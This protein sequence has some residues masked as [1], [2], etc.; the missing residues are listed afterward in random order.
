[1]GNKKIIQILKK[2]LLYLIKSC[3]FAAEYIQTRSRILMYCDKFMTEFM[4]KNRLVQPR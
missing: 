1:M 4:G 2:H 3:I